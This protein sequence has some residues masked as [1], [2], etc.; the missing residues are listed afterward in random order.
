MSISEKKLD[1][2]LFWTAASVVVAICAVVVGCYVNIKTDL[3][4]IKTVLII[5]GIMPSDLIAKGEEK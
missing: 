3:N 2:N 4:T 1:W 5:K